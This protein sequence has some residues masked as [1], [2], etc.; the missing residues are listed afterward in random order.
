MPCLGR[1]GVRP[2]A[3]AILCAFEFEV[4]PSTTNAPPVALIEREQIPQKWFR[5]DV[6]LGAL[7]LDLS[8]GA[9]ATAAAV[10]AFNAEMQRRIEQAIDSWLADDDPD[11]GGLFWAFPA[12]RGMQSPTITP[13]DVV[14]W[15]QT[16]VN[17]RNNRVI[18]PSW[19]TE[20]A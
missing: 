10:F 18:L 14:S 4:G 1:I 9:E 17:L 12:G 8:Q 15:D 3:I 2:S 5:L 7:K 11:N 13:A 6:D 16:L 20:M 19:S